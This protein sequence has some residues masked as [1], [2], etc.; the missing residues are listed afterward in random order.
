METVAKQFSQ[1]FGISGTAAENIVSAG[2][3]SL[4]SF[5]GV[6]VSDLKSIDGIGDVSADRIVS[7]SARLIL[8][9]EK[10]DLELANALLIEENDALKVS[11]NGK[12]LC[13]GDY[14]AKEKVTKKC[15]ICADHVQC[16]AL[17]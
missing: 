12:P 14:P 10:A 16:K 9:K 15:R 13:F 11:V 17:S 5:R 4:E 7:E 3:S 8:E 1:L 6:S 2:F